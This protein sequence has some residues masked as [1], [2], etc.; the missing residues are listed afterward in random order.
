MEK[1]KNYQVVTANRTEDLQRKVLALVEKGW[2]ISGGVSVAQVKQ[3][4]GG[5]F[6]PDGKDSTLFS[7]A[8]ILS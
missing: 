2:T 3:N 7:Q 6:T 5:G 8:M 4:A 1:I